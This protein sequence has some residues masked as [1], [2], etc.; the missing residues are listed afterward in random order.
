MTGRHEHP[1]GTRGVRRPPPRARHPRAWWVIAGSDAAVLAIVGIVYFGTHVAPHI[2]ATRAAELPIATSDGVP[3][4]TRAT[5]TPTP[6]GDPLAV[7]DVGKGDPVTH[8]A[9]S[10]VVGLPTVT[11]ETSTETTSETQTSTVSSTSETTSTETTQRDC[12][13][14]LFECDCD[15]WILIDC[16]GNPRFTPTAT[17]SSTEPEPDPTETTEPT[18]TSTTT[19]EPTVFDDMFDD[20]M[21]D[22]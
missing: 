21:E 3:P 18:A 5:V 15:H 20:L 6:T 4:I 13:D 12:S 22:W 9:R 11:S 8:A 16:D 10:T 17:S 1:D 14:P 19:S 2:D 7:A